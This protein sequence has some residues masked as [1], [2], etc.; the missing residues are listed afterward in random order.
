[1]KHKNLLQKRNKPSSTLVIF[2]LPVS[3]K[4]YFSNLYIN[5]LTVYHLFLKIK[6]KKSNCLTKFDL[7]WQKESFLWFQS[8][9]TWVHKALSYFTPHM[10]CLNVWRAEKGK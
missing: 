3:V 1:M 7:G 8:L 5:S 9:Q 2:W 10:F 6:K 4:I